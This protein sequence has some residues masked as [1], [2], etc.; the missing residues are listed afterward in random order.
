[1]TRSTR[2]TRRSGRPPTSRHC[3]Q[4]SRTGPSTAWPPIMPR[5][6]PSRRRPNGRRPRSACRAGGVGSARRP[7]GGHVGQAAGLPDR[8]GLP[9]NRGPDRPR[10][11]PA[12]RPRRACLAQPQLP[13]RWPEAARPG[14]RH[15]PARDGERAGRKAR[16]VNPG[17]PP[18]LLVLEDGTTFRG[19][20][21]GAE[22]EAFGEAV[23]NTAMTG[24]QE[25]LTDPSYCPQIVAMT[26]PHI[27]NTGINDE[28]NESRRIW[29][30]GVVIRNPSPL[31]SSCPPARSLDD[32][33]RAAGVTA[34]AISRTT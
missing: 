13:V 20:A 23:F 26:A 29:V 6:R 10:A 3:G 33:L 24:Y 30:S 9:G 34:I 17:A 5:T 18:A 14:D 1:M 19:T 32:E 28:D 15:V 4:A 8:A 11:D 21:Y 16:R 2:S 25:T 22:G 31:V 27:S 7:R 12:G